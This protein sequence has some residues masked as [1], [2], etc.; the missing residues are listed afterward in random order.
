MNNLPVSK[1]CIG[2]DVKRTLEAWAE[3]GST[4]RSLGDLDEER[5]GTE[6]KN[7]KNAAAR[8]SKTFLTIVART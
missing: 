5:L 7:I 3:V 4:L 6:V 1:P 2:L 8:P